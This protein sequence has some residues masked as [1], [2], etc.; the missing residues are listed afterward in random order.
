MIRSYSYILFLG[1]MVHPSC[2]PKATT[3]R[4]TT[5]GRATTTTTTSLPTKATNSNPRTLHL[6]THTLHSTALNSIIPSR[7]HSSS[8]NKHSCLPP[9][10]ARPLSLQKICLR[11]SVAVAIARVLEKWVSNYLKRQYFEVTTNSG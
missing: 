6:R 7:L 5:A 3:T 10:S 4:S 8:I 11:L 2:R 1:C 9:P